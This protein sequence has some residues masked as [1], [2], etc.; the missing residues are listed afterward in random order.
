LLFVKEKK[1]EFPKDV[2]KWLYQRAEK[3]N[4][5]VLDLCNVL[6]VKGG[7]LLAI[8]ALVAND[9]LHMLAAMPGGACLKV[10]VVVFGAA[11]LVAAILAVAELWPREYRSDQLPAD[12]ERWA[13]DLLE[14]YRKYPISG[15]DSD[16][17]LMGQITSAMFGRLSERVSENAKLN[18]AKLKCLS[19]SFRFAA[20]SMGLYVVLALVFR[21]I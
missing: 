13:S 14:Y 20:F 16:S 11:L 18:E 21:R 12:D 8:I 15:I 17:T 9:P 2:A 4:A 10:L 6:D 3:K 7:I 19:W 1:M 5:Y